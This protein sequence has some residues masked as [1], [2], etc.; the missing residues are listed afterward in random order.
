MT[1]YEVKFIN[2]LF[3]LINSG[4]AIIYCIL[5]VWLLSQLFV[6]LSPK[7][8]KAHIYVSRLVCIKTLRNGWSYIGLSMPLYASREKP[9]VQ[10]RL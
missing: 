9:W 6:K 3:E 10:H 4:E 8:K 1:F 5:F 2:S 7:V